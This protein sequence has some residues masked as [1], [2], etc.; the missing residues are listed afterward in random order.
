MG[1]E[2]AVI[3]PIHLEIPGHGSPKD[4][5]IVPHYFKFEAPIAP[6][7]VTYKAP[8]NLFYLY[9]V[10]APL[11]WHVSTHVSKARMPLLLLQSCRMRAPNKSCSV[12][13]IHSLLFSSYCCLAPMKSC[14]TTPT[15]PRAGILP[16][17]RW[18]QLQAAKRPRFSFSWCVGVDS[19]SRHN[20]KWLSVLSF[21]SKGD[22]SVLIYLWDRLPSQWEN[23]PLIKIG[24]LLTRA[25]LAFPEL[26]DAF[27]YSSL[28]RQTDLK[29]QRLICAQ[30]G[31]LM[32]GPICRAN[33]KLA[34]AVAFFFSLC[35]FTWQIKH[36]HLFCVYRQMISPLVH[37]CQ[38]WKIPDCQPRHS[39]FAT[40]AF[41]GHC[42]YKLN[43]TWPAMI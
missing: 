25:D 1:G 23:L 10:P 43:S 33:C 35:M 30:F 14:W 16:P 41:Q 40:L 18:L 39:G 37:H 3:F 6:H 7:F 12:C 32:F 31:G 4:I 2:K 28:S 38:S 13:E 19:I 20:S 17:N 24:L 15:K 36:S 27:N 22:V 42:W 5:W 11:L 21:L 34:E 29:N 26:L 8:K 9:F